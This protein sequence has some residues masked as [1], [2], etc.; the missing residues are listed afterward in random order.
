MP[1][2]S[3]QV[4]QTLVFPN[5]WPCRLIF[6]TIFL[7]SSE[8]VPGVHAPGNSNSFFLADFGNYRSNL[9]VTF[10]LNT[11]LFHYFFPCSWYCIKC[12]LHSSFKSTTKFAWEEVIVL[13]HCCCV[14]C[15]PTSQ[16]MRSSKSK[17]IMN[18][19]LYEIIT[20][21]FL[22]K[23]HQGILRKPICWSCGFWSCTGSPGPQYFLPLTRMD[24]KDA[25]FIISSILLSSFIFFRPRL[26]IFHWH[27][28]IYSRVLLNRT[29]INMS[30]RA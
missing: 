4:T 24:S 10:F 22:A 7:T 9:N 21:F 13:F 6:A 17:R 8:K 2:P 25:P 12:F 16:L 11:L 20:V 29:I 28:T 23:Y 3:P 26:I 1:A 30:T 19:S 5:W 15:I 14:C 27:I 18:V